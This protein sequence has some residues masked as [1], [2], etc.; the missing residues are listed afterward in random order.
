MQEQYRQLNVPI[1]IVRTLIAISETG[2]L[3]KAASRLGLTQPAVSAQMKRIETMIGG[4]IFKKGAGGS[5]A[6]KLGSLVLNHARRM[7]D[8]NDQMLRLRG[9]SIV[10]APARIRLGISNLYVKEYLKKRDHDL[11]GDVTIHT[12]NS[13]ELTKELADGF[14]DIA[15]VFRTAELT[16]DMA[17]FIV[18]EHDEQFVWARASD[19]LLSPG[20]PLPILSWS[21]AVTDALMISALSRK[22][23]PYRVAFNSSDY[24]AKLSAAEAGLGLTIIPRRM[25]PATLVEAKDDYLPPLPPLKAFLCARPDPQRSVETAEILS[26]LSQLLFARAV[27]PAA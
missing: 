2:S 4:S 12:D 15:C 9:N 21:G 20:V 3:T 1:E 10:D 24:Q 8:A 26:H 14:I 6:T 17:D 11:L 23:L 22:G 7:M 19:F 13:A 18:D 16:N 5:A 27:D 25:L